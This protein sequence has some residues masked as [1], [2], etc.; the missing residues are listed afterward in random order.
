MFV[1][2]LQQH[3]IGDLPV[4][5]EAR[6][7]AIAVRVVDRGVDALR[8]GVDA[9]T[10]LL[11]VAKAAGD[12]DRALDRAVVVHRRTDLGYW[13]IASAFRGHVDDAG[14]HGE[15]VVE[16]RCTLEHFEALLVLHG[17]RNIVVERQHAVEVIAGAVVQRDAAQRQVVVRQA[18]ELEPGHAGHVAQRVVQAGRLLQVEQVAGHHVYRGGNIQDVLPLEGT[19]LDPAGRKAL[20]TGGSDA[21]FLERGAP[22]VGGRIVGK[23]H[24]AERQARKG[25]RKRRRARGSLE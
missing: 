15:A 6:H 17:N 7:V 4:G 12:I 21:D 20:R 11:V 19:H 24:R 1:V 10:E 25:G 14:G 9:Y 13:R 18:V 16:R 8:G 23:G 3:A 2:V 22:D 5:G